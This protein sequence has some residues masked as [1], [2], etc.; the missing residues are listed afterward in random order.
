MTGVAWLGARV[1]AEDGPA[2]L[3]LDTYDDG[4]TFLNTPW[5]PCEAEVVGAVIVT[6]GTE[7]HSLHAASGGRP[8]PER[9]ERRQSGLRLLRRVLRRQLPPEWII[10]NGV[11][12]P[13]TH[14]FAFIDPGVFDSAVTKAGCASA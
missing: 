14:S 12:T 10:Q 7:L 5:M 8:V 9:L 4:V 6:A 13:G 3:D 11:V 1:S 2:S